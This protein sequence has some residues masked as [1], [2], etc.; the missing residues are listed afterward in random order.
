MIFSHLPY[1]GDAFLWTIRKC[2]VLSA[3]LGFANIWHLTDCKITCTWRVRD[4]QT[5]ELKWHV[6]LS[7]G[8]T[9]DWLHMELLLLS[10]WTILS[11]MVPWLCYLFHL[12]CY[13]TDLYLPR[14]SVIMIQE[15]PQ[16]WTPCNRSKHTLLHMHKGWNNGYTVNLCI[17]EWFMWLCDLNINFCECLTARVFREETEN[18]STTWPCTC[19]SVSCERNWNIRIPHFCVS[20]GCNRP[21]AD[22]T[23]LSVNHHCGQLSM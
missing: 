18:K 12:D 15:V 22:G 13:S 21:W 10:H 16:T 3:H 8:R 14:V 1:F 17:L 23:E 4:S 5:G 7:K 19:T 6:H 2:W 9:V 20:R 11:C